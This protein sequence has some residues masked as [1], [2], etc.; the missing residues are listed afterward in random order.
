MS[1]Q[2]VDQ[3]PQKYSVF[4]D[5]TIVRNG[6]K[7]QRVMIATPWFDDPKDLA[8]ILREGLGD[9]LS[10][11]GTAVLS[12]KIALLSIGQV[13][14]V[15]TIKVGKFARL[16][17]KYV[18]PQG[19]SKAQSIPERMQFVIQR[20]GWPRTLLA[21]AASAVTRPFGI[22]GAFYVVAGREARDLD[23]MHGEYADRLLP[24]LSPKQAKKIVD[25]V[26]AELG[27]PVAI[28]DINDRGGH[29]R[30]VSNDGLDAKL[31]LETMDDN[32]MGQSQGTPLG[33]VRLLDS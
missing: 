5:E 22:R 28:V 11:G 10:S 1:D 16:A 18:R 7:Y 8:A 33:M 24:P 12:E 9:Y 14:S 32:P 29:I 25:K 3:A 30:A 6:R 15:S 4:S 23:G 27:A 21:C 2:A 13:V 20:I 31:V 17:S 19:Y 26:A